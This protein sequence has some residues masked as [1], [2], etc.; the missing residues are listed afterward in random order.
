MTVS[1]AWAKL[2]AAQG[3]KKRR[4]HSEVGPVHAKA[5]DWFASECGCRGKYRLGERGLLIWTPDEPCRQH[6]APFD[7][8]AVP[9]CEPVKRI[10][11]A[12]PPFQGV[13]WKLPCRVCEA[14]EHGTHEW[15]CV[16]WLVTDRVP[17]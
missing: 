15:D 4:S 3:K 16:F 12:A 5:G 17:F 2:L 6:R 8:A 10:S 1:P 14:T 7:P 13:S 11:E 9:A